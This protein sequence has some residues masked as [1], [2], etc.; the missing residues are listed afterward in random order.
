MADLGESHERIVARGVPTARPSDRKGMSPCALGV[1]E[2]FD[3]GA[4]SEVGRLGA[5]CNHEEQDGVSVYGV[6][7]A[8]Q[9]G[10]TT[11]N[12]ESAELGAL[13]W[14]MVSSSLCAPP[15]VARAFAGTG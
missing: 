6:D 14:G 3:A 13:S 2:C 7:V 1:E 4:D 12:R 10:K 5:D 11:Q 9:L 15:T 8:N